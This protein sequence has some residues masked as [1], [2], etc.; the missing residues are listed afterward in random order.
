MVTSHKFN[1]NDIVQKNDSEGPEMKVMYSNI[2]Y[3]VPNQINV[4]CEYYDEIQKINRILEFNQHELMLVR[5][6]T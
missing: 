4:I 1:K 2:N 5:R 6:A 3:F